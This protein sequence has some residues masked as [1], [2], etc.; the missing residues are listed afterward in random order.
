MMRLRAVFALILLLVIAVPLGAQ[1]EMTGVYVYNAWLVSDD[2]PNGA[3]YLT[4]ENALK[5]AVMLTGVTTPVG[6]IMLSPRDAEPLAVAPGESIVLTPDTAALVVT[7]AEDAPPLD[8]GL[9]LTL[10]FEDADGALYDVPTGALPAD[11]ASDSGDMVVLSGWARPTALSE[12]DAGDPGEVISGAYLTLE[13][14]GDEADALVSLGSPRVAAVELHETQMDGGMMR[15][16]PLVALTLEPGE[17]HALTPGGEHL[18]LIGL[19]S[20]LL[21]GQVVPLTLT[22]ESGQTLTVAVPVIDEREATGPQTEATES[23]HM[24]H[25]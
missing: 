25:H 8:D 5:T 19:E 2:G 14:R 16:R 21:P 10:T 3:V 13:N 22:F 9:A 15:M 20:H 4:I 12:A 7:T 18:M 11:A 24:G 17:R 23:G 1:E 6:E